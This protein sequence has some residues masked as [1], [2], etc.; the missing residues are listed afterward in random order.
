MLTRD[1]MKAIVDETIALGNELRAFHGHTDR[2]A[3]PRPPATAAALKVFEARYPERVPPSYLQL[4][5]ICDGVDNFDWVDVS[6]LS[7]DFLLANDDL[8]EDWIEAE[9]FDE[10]EVFIFAQSDDDAHAIGF[11]TKK[12]AKDGEMKV[13]DVAA[14]LEPKE[15]KNLEDYL[16]RRRDWF[17]KY[18]AR[19]KADRAALSEGE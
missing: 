3:R 19:E 11:H 9:Y 17:A 12:K 6:L 14:S 16:R 5:S 18:V 10:G 1:Q 13:V 15:Y 8:D 2:A 4:L 7:T